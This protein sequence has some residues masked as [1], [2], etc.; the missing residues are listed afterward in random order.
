MLLRIQDKG[1]RKN[2]RKV[3][4]TKADLDAEAS[5]LKLQ[6][7]L[8]DLP[9]FAH[10]PRPKDMSLLS[11]PD[12]TTPVGRT[13]THHLKSR[14]ANEVGDQAQQGTYKSSPKYT[15]NRMLGVSVLHKS[16]GIP[17]FSDEEIKDISKMR[18]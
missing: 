8:D 6:A 16:N 3:K 7:K 2:K 11:M 13:N 5:F 15:G 17:V 12:L 10:T 4:L 9:K 1:R 14:N 18:R